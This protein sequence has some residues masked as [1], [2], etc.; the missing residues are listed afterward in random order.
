[1][2]RHQLFEL[3]DKPIDATKRN[4][5]KETILAKELDSLKV[6]RDD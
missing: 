2:L 5:H 3:S 4:E 1:M 6:L